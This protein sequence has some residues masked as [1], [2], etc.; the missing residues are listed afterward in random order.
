MWLPEDRAI[1]VSSRI[2]DPIAQRSTLAHMLGHVDLGDSRMMR[3]FEKGRVGVQ[4]VER[5][6]R[7]DVSRRLIPF[8]ALLTALDEAGPYADDVA[9]ELGVPVRKL[10][11]RIRSMTHLE[12]MVAGR[13]VMDLTWPDMR[14]NLLT[15]CL[16]GE[17]DTLPRTCAALAVITSGIL[18][19]DHASLLIAS[20]ANW[21]N[22]GLPG[23]F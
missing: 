3:K 5:R 22:T 11:V 1:I 6:V 20:A 7:R 18:F 19:G 9:E 16:V 17:T 8:D 2:E 10:A 14:N 15:T 12:A 21:P 23:M 4:K 13:Q